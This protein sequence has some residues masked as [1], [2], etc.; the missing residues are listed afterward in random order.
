M[1]NLKNP[2]TI[3]AFCLLSAAVAHAAP[4]LTTTVDSGPGQFTV[5]STDLVNAGQPTLASPPSTT[6]YIQQSGFGAVGVI[7]DGQFTT[8][9]SDGMLDTNS[10]PNVVNYTVRFDLDTSTNTLGYD[11]SEINTYSYWSDERYSQS[12]TVFYS[13]VGDPNFQQLGSSRFTLEGLDQTRAAQLNITDDTNPN[14]ATNVDAIEFRFYRPISGNSS[15]DGV[16]YE[17]DV[18]GTPTIPEPGSLILVGAGS[19]L[20][21]VRRREIR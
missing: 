13:V 18:F 9:Q 16:Y 21:L 7:N 15:S 17:I 3:S 4:V 14:L 12:Y 19:A 1:P 8:N 11:I 10:T 2:M 6:N 5:S 20:L